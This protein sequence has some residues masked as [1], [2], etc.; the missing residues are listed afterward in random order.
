MTD[1]RMERIR[2]RAYLLWLDAGCPAGRDLEHWLVAEALENAGTAAF[3][4]ELANGGEVSGEAFVDSEESAQAQTK[5]AI[6]ARRRRRADPS[7]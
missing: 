2:H 4:V 3:D 5:V 7:A 1:H 6:A